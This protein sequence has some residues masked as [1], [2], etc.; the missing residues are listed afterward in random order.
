[1]RILALRE[2]P[3]NAGAGDFREDLA[4]AQL[5]AGGPP[6][7]PVHRGAAH[8]GAGTDRRRAGQDDA[9]HRARQGEPGP[10]S[11]RCAATSPPPGADRRWVVDFV[12]HEAP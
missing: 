7:G 4:A 6:G 8:A 10:R 3:F 12:R 5:P 1:M 11:A 2:E 9:H